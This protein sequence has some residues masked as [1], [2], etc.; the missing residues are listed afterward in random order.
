[1]HD[2]TPTSA[3][4]RFDKHEAPDGI[5]IAHVGLDG[6]FLLCNRR[7]AEIAGY[8]PAELQQLTFHD[9]THPDDL[10]NDVDCARRLAAGEIPTYSMEKRY[11]RKDGQPVWIRLAGSVVRDDQGA[12]RYFIAA[13]EEIE[14]RKK[15]EAQ[16]LRWQRLFEAADFGM[17]QVDITNNSFIEVNPAFARQRGYTP[18]ELLGRKL[19]DIY[20]PES[21]EYLQQNLAIIDSTGHSVFEAVH[22]RKDGSCFPV[23]VEVTVVKDV[24]GQ[25]VSRVAYALD[26]SERKRVEEALR[27]AHAE[28]ARH[29]V[30]LETVLDNM[31]EGLVV[32]DLEGKVYHWNRAAL[33]MHGFASLDECRR[34]LHEFR[35]IFELSD[36]DGKVVPFEHWP[37]SRILKGE[38]IRNLELQLR[39]LGSEWRRIYSYSGTLAK[40]TNNAPLLAVLNIGDVTERKRNEAALQR[41]QLIADHSRDIILFIRRADGRILDANYAATKVYGYSHAELLG[42]TIYDLRATSTL[43]QAEAQLSAADEGGVLFETMHRRKDGTIFPVGVSSQ[44]ST[45]AG[46]R[47]LISVVRDITQRK[48]YEEELLRAREAAEAASQAKSKFLAS[49]SHEIR[50]PMTVFL[51]ALELL[52]QLDR[53]PQRRQLLDLAEQSAQRLHALINDVLDFSRIEADRVELEAEPFDL[54]DSLEKVV[55]MMKPMAG[56]KGLVLALDVAAAVPRYVVGDQ[57]RLEQ[58][59]INLVSNA[60][61][62]TAQGEVRIAAQT[63]GVQLTF[64][65]SDT[66]IGIPEEK[67]ELIFQAFSQV[68]SSSTRR[69]GGTGLG[70]AISRRLVELMGGTIGVRSRVGVGSEFFFSLPLQTAGQPRP[71]PV[72][73]TAACQAPA[74]APR[75]IL[76]AEDNPQVRDIVLVMLSQR[77]WTVTAVDDGG[78]AVRRWQAE[79]FD[80]VLMDLQMP[81]MDGLEATRRI[82]A[83]AAEL[84]KKAYIVGLTA[85]ATP[86]M[87]EECLRTGMDEVLVKPF[88]AAQLYAVIE[89]GL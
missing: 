43:E 8:A 33:E 9:I 53:N 25:P 81:D 72:T 64:I 57:Y 88:E 45:V 58:I 79:S 18:E 77:G 56:D 76:L 34:Q 15:A 19:S 70:L 59:L 83:L 7:F 6:R 13:I 14:T 22:Q 38:H 68:D 24:D 29:L 5:G 4:I 62:F 80:V 78:E 82:R 31:T 27:S 11:I 35:H 44:G 47:M 74:F 73:D 71:A 75:R 84:Q 28:S 89:K 54:P 23:L 60:I 42:L 3:S 10:A 67:Q 20:P 69:F 41:Y 50:T 40:G 85:H 61:K 12:P 49:V 63:D 37:M 46:E 30:Q 66:G 1:M 65:V 17:V 16:A 52:Q 21:H 55:R 51:G 48:R 86:A 32:A 26:I 39:R 2:D 87:R 36:L